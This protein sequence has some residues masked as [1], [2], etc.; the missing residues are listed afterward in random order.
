VTC[1][2]RCCVA[3]TQCARVLVLSSKDN[4]D[5]SRLWARFSENGP[6]PVNLKVTPQEQRAARKDHEPTESVM[7]RACGKAFALF[8]YLAAFLREWKAPMPHCLPCG[9]RHA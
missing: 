2:C 1:D 4:S 6:Q 9:S 8:V 3:G 5:A 7:C